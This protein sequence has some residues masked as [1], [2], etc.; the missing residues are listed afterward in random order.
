MR[1]W[2]ETKQLL[3]FKSFEAPAPLQSACNPEHELV[4]IRIIVMGQLNGNPGEQYELTR[5][6]NN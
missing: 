3:F 1:V 5:I 6:I 4:N 2:K